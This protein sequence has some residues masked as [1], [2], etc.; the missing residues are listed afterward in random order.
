MRL[1]QD[2]PDFPKLPESLPRR[3]MRDRLTRPVLVRA[4][5]SLSRIAGETFPAVIGGQA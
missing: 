5:K 3:D 1:S 4:G 2:S